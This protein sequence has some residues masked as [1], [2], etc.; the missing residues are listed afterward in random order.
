M[1]G[2]EYEINPVDSH[3]YFG[4]TDWSDSDNGYIYY[5][6]SIQ[7]HDLAHIPE[8]MKGVSIPYHK[9]VAFR[10]VGFFLRPD[11][12]NGRQVGRLLVHMYYKWIY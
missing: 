3:V 4:Y 10:F 6:P 11:D 12:I 1:Q 7:V 5:V 8:G 2:A 9:Y